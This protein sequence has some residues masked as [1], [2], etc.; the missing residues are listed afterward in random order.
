M[1]EIIYRKA[2][3]S[4]LD[5]LSV[6]AMEL[7]EFH[8]S[9]EDYFELKIENKSRMKSFFEQ[10][11]ASKNHLFFVAEK[12]KEIIAYVHANISTRPP[13]FVHEKEV[14]I[15][16]MFTKKEYR[17]KGIANKLFLEVKKF[18]KE[19]KLRFIQLRVYS[20][21]NVAKKFYK[22]LGFEVMLDYM[23]KKV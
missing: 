13:I 19:N 10:S 17:K 20:K 6:L 3:K 2:R 5:S 18:A 15:G 9:K 23:V 22:A 21:N 7:N 12:D 8:D 11:I 16:A 4:D 1:S 14:Y